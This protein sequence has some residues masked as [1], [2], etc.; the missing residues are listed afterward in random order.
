MPTRLER[1]DPPPLAQAGTASPLPRPAAHPTRTRSRRR[2]SPCSSARTAA[3]SPRRLDSRSG[4]HNPSA[5]DWW[6]S[7]LSSTGAVWLSNSSRF[8]AQVRDATTPTPIAAVAAPAVSQAAVREP[9]RPLPVGISAPGQRLRAVI[10]RS[11]AIGGAP[12]TRARRTSTCCRTPL[13]HRERLDRRPVAVRAHLHR[14][15]PVAHAHRLGKRQCAH[16]L[17]V[18]DHLGPRR[19]THNLHLANGCPHTGEHTIRVPAGSGVS[20]G[21]AARTA[22]RSGVARPEASTRGPPRPARSW[23]AVRAVVARS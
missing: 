4:H 3:R 13:T 18:H 17:P 14:N 12:A 15:R 9:A 22:P 6:P 5:Y 11:V 2:S 10:R 1:D 8:P 7:Q 20:T 23:A 21:R 19:L 16:R